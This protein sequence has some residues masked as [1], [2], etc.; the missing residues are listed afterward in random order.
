[1]GSNTSVINKESFI[2]NVTD[3]STRILSEDQKF[4]ST[5]QDFNQ[6]QKVTLSGVT[7]NCG[8]EAV[9]SMTVE[10]KVFNQLNAESE[11]DLANQLRDQMESILNNSIDQAQSGISLGQVNTSVE[12]TSANQEIMNDMS[13]RISRIISQS[14][15]NALQAKQGQ[16]FNFVNT[17]FEC[18]TDPNGRGLLLRQNLDVKSVIENSLSSLE[19]TDITNDEDTL[20]LVESE[21][22]ASQTVSGLFNDTTMIVIGV[23]IG[24]A[25]LAGAVAAYFKVIKPRWQKKGKTETDNS[26][27]VDF[28]NLFGFTTKRKRRRRK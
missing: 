23:V 14:I 9:Q 26:S 11:L 10:T 19:A 18:P 24:L 17:K 12:N 5:S 2:K 22:D 27:T 8:F 28:G 7:V 20:T 3:A 15:N 25:L 13:T 1:M 6:E 16:E 4:S 21:S